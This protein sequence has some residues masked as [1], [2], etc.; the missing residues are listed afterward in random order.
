[1]SAPIRFFSFILHLKRYREMS[2]QGKRVA[3]YTLGC[4][5]NFAETASI[6]RQF[7]AEGYRQVPFDE[8]ADVYFINSCTV[9]HHADRKCRSAIRRAIRKNPGAFVAVGG[10][11]A[12]VN[13]AEISQIEGVD[14]ILGSREKFRLFQLF[15]DFAKQP[16][17]DI[18]V[19]SARRAPTFEPAWSLTDRTR[20]FLKVQDG[21]DYFCS[22]CT[23][24]LA[25]G[26][27]RS[28]SIAET[29]KAAGEIAARGKKEIV[30]TG[31]NIG[32]FGREKG[33][34]F[35][36]L[37]RELDRLEG[38]ERY[39]IS[40]IEPNLLSDE[41]IEQVH[42]SRKFLPH[43]HI[44]LQSGSDEILSAMRRRYDTRLFADRVAKIRSLMPLAGIG[45]DVIT[46]FPGE[47]EAHM[48]QQ[49][50]FLHEVDFSY[51][52]VF[53][54]S[55]RPQTRA[56]RMKGKI[57]P[58]EIE[59]R[60][61]RLHELSERKHRLFMERNLGTRNRVLFETREKGSVTGW[62]ENYLKFATTDPGAT[63]GSIKTV[64]LD[65]LDGEERLTGNLTP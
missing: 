2:M 60:S 57:T 30:L 23:I 1:M 41:I 65:A 38:I 49:D 59:A 58:R 14:A 3:F 10:C 54:F 28:A 42:E 46:G 35:L 50:R 37:I 9:T 48:E 22:Y 25:R 29:L 33:E 18:R 45:V 55:E 34:S 61:H 31:I 53:S 26:A 44:P 8:E 5:L 27:N 63:P 51:L 15:G 36:N 4:K 39:R 43:F 19:E 40:S 11:Y 16:A 24:P 17:P 12:Q 20:S 32:E 56:A 47:T 7:E 64:S 62:T 6:A 13:A 21:C 52:H